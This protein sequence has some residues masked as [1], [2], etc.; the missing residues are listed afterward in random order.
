MIINTPIIYNQIASQTSR[1]KQSEKQNYYIRPMNIPYEL[2]DYFENKNR[3]FYINQYTVRH[4]TIRN[5]L[6]LKI[7]VHIM[8]DFQLP[9]N[10]FYLDINSSIGVFKN[11][12]LVEEATKE[13]RFSS[14]G[15]RIQHEFMTNVSINLNETGLSTQE[16]IKQMMEF[17]MQI[18]ITDDVR[19]HDQINYISNR[20]SVL[21][22]LNWQK[23][24]PYIYY[25]A[26]TFPLNN[27]L[28][29]NANH[30]D[31]IFR[32]A[33][34]TREHHF[35]NNKR[36]SELGNLNVQSWMY[37]QRDDVVQIKFWFTYKNL[38]NETKRFEWIEPLDTLNEN[39]NPETKVLKLNPKTPLRYD[40]LNDEIVIDIQNGFRG[41]WL[42]KAQTVQLNAT[43]KTNYKTPATYKIKQ[44]LVFD[45]NF[46][47]NNK[48]L[49]KIESLEIKNYEGFTEI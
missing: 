44:D 22:T 13:I 39:F 6:Q 18:K 34:Y 46:I 35:K 17:R 45:N 32:L 20:T 10:Y 48:P 26:N 23:L 41:I 29:L 19:V 5:V 12:S 38:A 3:V 30:S 28:N 31:V 24:R 1:H 11:L 27:P 43:I 49:I 42:P 37:V 14:G 36:A 40:F 47:S 16:I 21:K 4:E 15:T 2:A 8:G 9:N 33:N 25:Y 7:I